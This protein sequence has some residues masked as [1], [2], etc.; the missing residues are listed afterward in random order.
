M[1]IT[2]YLKDYADSKVHSEIDK[3]NEEQKFRIKRFIDEIIEKTQRDFVIFDLEILS[4]RIEISL[5][6]K[7]TML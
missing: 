3:L 5:N 6:Y 7:I 4:D 1:D 2:K